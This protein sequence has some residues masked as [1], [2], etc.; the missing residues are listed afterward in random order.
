MT[1]YKNAAKLAL[2][3]YNNDNKLLLKI[4]ILIQ[5]YEQSINKLEQMTLTKGKNLFFYI[6]RNQNDLFFHFRVK[7]FSKYFSRVYE[8]SENF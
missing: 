6:L 3:K 1:Q 4:K 8:L 2:N 7:G 5:R